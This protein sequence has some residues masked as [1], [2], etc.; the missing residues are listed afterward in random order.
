PLVNG[1]V[2]ARW[3]VEAIRAMQEV[4]EAAPRMWAPLLI[5][6]GTEDK[7]ASFEATQRVFEA[8]GSS[9]KELIIYPGF[10]HELFNE[11]CK[12]EVYD[13]VT[14]WIEARIGGPRS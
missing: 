13:R 2:S 6:H 14:G 3:F 5:M 1:L 4:E 9:D 8:I 12:Q 11:P 10:Y 7:L